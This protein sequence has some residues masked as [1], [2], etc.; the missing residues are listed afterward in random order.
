MDDSNN[1]GFL[2]SIR[3]ARMEWNILKVKVKNGHLRILCPLK[4]FFKSEGEIKMFSETRKQKEFSFSRPARRKMMPQGNLKNLR[5]KEE[6]EMV[7]IC[8]NI[9]NHFLLNFFKICI[10][11]GRNLTWSDKVFYICNITH[12]KLRTKKES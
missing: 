12:M 4:I 3:W 8:V 6:I 5:T 11:V 1:Y 10:R 2:I 7:N 9:L